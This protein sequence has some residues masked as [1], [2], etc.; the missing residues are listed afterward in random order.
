MKLFH[1]Q[2]IDY[3]SAKK[4]KGMLV[5]FVNFESAEQVKRATEVSL[6]LLRN[7]PNPQNLTITFPAR[8]LICHCHRSSMEH[9]LATRF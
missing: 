4:K 7:I 9:L 8:F 5:G 6:T 3:K 1:S 2:G